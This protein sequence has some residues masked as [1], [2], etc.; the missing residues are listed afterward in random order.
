MLT[1]IEISTKSKMLEQL[2]LIQQLYPEFT[3]KIYGEL[4]EQMI[5]NNYKQAVVFEN[6]IGIGLSGFWVGTKLWSGKYLELDNVIVHP[7]HRSKG[8]G[9]LLTDYLIQKAIAIGCKQIALDAYTQNFPA[10]KFYYNQGFVPKGFHF[11]KF[12][13]D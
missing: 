11:V 6:E 4:L 13:E 8:V 12:L 3:L 2:H 7:N 9:K 5:P 1:I 10:H